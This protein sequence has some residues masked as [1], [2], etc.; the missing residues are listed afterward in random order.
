MFASNECRTRLAASQFEKHVDR[1]FVLNERRRNRQCG[2]CS[3]GARF[4]SLK[5]VHIYKRRS[6]NELPAIIFSRNFLFLPTLLTT[7]VRSQF[8][9]LYQRKSATSVFH[10]RYLHYCL[11]HKRTFLSQ[12][13]GGLLSHRYQNN[14]VQSY[15]E[16]NVCVN[17]FF[18]N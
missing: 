6:L 2:L 18:A 15:W 13:R 7:N 11:Q 14:V 8:T 3:A 10:C 1:G 12:I 9:H 4:L 17:I 16:K 5:I